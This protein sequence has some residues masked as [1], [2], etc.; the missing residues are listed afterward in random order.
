[1]LAYPERCGTGPFEVRLPERDIAW[2]RITVEVLGDRE[3]PLEFRIFLGSG[4]EDDSWH[5]LGTFDDDPAR[6]ERCRIATS[7]ATTPS[8][9]TESDVAAPRGDR[10]PR[11]AVGRSRELEVGRAPVLVPFQGRLTG[12]VSQS[13]GHTFFPH[14]VPFDYGDEIPT[15]SF[16]EPEARAAIVLRLWLRE[17]GDFEGLVLRIRDQTLVPDRPLQE[18]E[19]RFDERRAFE[20][21][22]TSDLRS[23]EPLARRRCEEHHDGPSCAHRQRLAVAVP[24]LPLHEDT[25]ASPGGEATWV[26]GFWRFVPGHDE[27]AGAYI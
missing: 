5:S 15:W 4:Q 14:G 16:E 18:Y 25:P 1:V 2:G 20:L 12:F 17:P 27:E 9:M 21:L 13:M 26:P 24:P 7:A 19:A 10:S 23:D 11:S 6:H 3:L 8:P 22:R